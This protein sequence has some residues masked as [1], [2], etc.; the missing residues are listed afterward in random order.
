MPPTN[1]IAT[2][3][4]RM[5]I[6]SI[7]TRRAIPAATPPMIPRSGSRRRV[8]AADALMGAIFAASVPV[9]GAF[10]ARRDQDRPDHREQQRPAVAELQ[11]DRV[12]L[13]EQQE[14]AGDDDHQTR[15][16]RC[17]VQPPHAHLFPPSKSL[18]PL[19]ILSPLKNFS[20]SCENWSRR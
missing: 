19:L 11:V 16:E 6:G 20:P 7:P 4:T 10:E 3:P 2:K 9:T 17:P 14:N 5:R 1:V 8:T 18:M 15:D 13:I 12:E